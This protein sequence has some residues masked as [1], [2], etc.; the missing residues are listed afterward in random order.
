VESSAVEVEGEWSSTEE[1][2][3]VLRGEFYRDRLK[4]E[5]ARHR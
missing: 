1:E 3:E 2:E 5:Q 4:G